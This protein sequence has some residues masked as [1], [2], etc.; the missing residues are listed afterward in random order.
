ML[1]VAGLVILV[2]VVIAVVDG[3]AE[4]AET[5]ARPAAAASATGTK[6]QRFPSPLPEA[7]DDVWTRYVRL[8][9]TGRPE[10]ISP[11]G[12]L[13]IFGLGPKRLEDL[14]FVRSSRK[15]ERDGRQVWEAEWVAPYSLER[16]LGDGALQYKAFAKST[17]D[18]R[19]RILE[20]HADA[21]GK[22]FATKTATLSGLL[23]VAHQAGLR[24]LARWL[25]DEGDRQRF[26]N[27]TAAFIKATGIF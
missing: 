27:T 10:N 3:R 16:F 22:T 12:H 2:A 6:L 18:H 25:E 20:R 1:A 21:V 4:A 5:D 11:G 26:P 13:G 8:M 14:A 9:A 17:L 7:T 23:A 24:G 15:V 19:A